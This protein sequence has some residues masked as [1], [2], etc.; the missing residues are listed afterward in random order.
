[1][2]RDKFSPRG[3]LQLATLRHGIACVQHEI[4]KRDFQ[5]ILIS[6][7]VSQGLDNASR[8]FDWCAGSQC[9]GEELSEIIKK[10]F[11][12]HC[13]ALKMLAAREGQQSLNEYTS[14]V[15]RLNGSG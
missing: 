1:M 12:V 8:H 9:A 3:D 14:A 2:L 13:A 10:Y 7:G 11:D 15:R 5:L 4:K 6:L